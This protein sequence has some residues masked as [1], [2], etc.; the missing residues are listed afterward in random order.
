[1]F[2]DTRTIERARNDPWLVGFELA[3]E[4][5]LLDLTGSWARRAGA[6]LAINFGPRRRGRDWSRAIYDA[7]PGIEGLYYPAPTDASRPAVL[8]YERAADSLPERPV[9]HRALADDALL[10]VVLRVA[11]GLGY[12]VV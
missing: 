3:R 1:V 11:Q 8:L 12:A 9:F 4:V 7:Y 2:Q 5:R 6:S 10:P